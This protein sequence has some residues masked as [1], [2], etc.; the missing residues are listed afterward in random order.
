MWEAI[1]KKRVYHTNRNVAYVFE[2]YVEYVLVFEV[3]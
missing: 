3:R 1:F 2:E